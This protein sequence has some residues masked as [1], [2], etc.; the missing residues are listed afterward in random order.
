MPVSFGLE[1]QPFVQGQLGELADR[2][3]ASEGRDRV[4]AFLAP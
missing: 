1:F 3:V 2:H 4:V